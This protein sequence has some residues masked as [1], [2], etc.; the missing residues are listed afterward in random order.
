MRKSS[1]REMKGEARRDP[2]AKESSGR[3]HTSQVDQS[4]NI[5]VRPERFQFIISLGTPKLKPV[6]LIVGFVQKVPSSL[7]AATMGEPMSAP[8]FDENIPSP[9]EDG[10][11]SPTPSHSE[12]MPTSEAPSSSPTLSEK[13]PI[14]LPIED[15][16]DDETLSPSEAP[17]MMPSMEQT[18]PP[19]TATQPTNR[20]STATQPTNTP[21]EPPSAAGDTQVVT[22][23]ATAEGL[24]E[25][26]PGEVTEP[27][28]SDILKL[29][30][31]TSAFY[32][33]VFSQ[34]YRDSEDTVFLILYANATDVKYDPNATIPIQVEWEF[35]VYFDATSEVIP[36][37]EEILQL[38]V[39]NEDELQDYVEIYLRSVDSI[40]NS[41]I[42]VTFVPVDVEAITGRMPE[43]TTSAS[44]TEG[45]LEVKS[46]FPVTNVEA[47]LM[48]GFDMSDDGEEPD[49]ADFSR[50]ESALNVFYNALLAQVYLFNDDTKVASVVT[51]ITDHDF[52][53]QDEIQLMA[54]VA[55][56]VFF[57]ELSTFI[58]SSE[59]VLALLQANSGQL[60]LFITEGFAWGDS[61]V[62]NHVSN[63]TLKPL[64]PIQRQ[65]GKGAGSI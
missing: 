23:N 20:P 38:I 11:I 26:A 46:S 39:S 40:W 16:P 32:I 7:Y 58:P 56:N 63:V 33:G 9:S 6:L 17:S 1:R 2:K 30:I 65:R 44:P 22:S 48:F 12:S 43:P 31:G 34:Y 64:T 5:Q 25:F 54:D 61:H 36:S 55:Y 27:T 50:L 42:R 24:Y 51:S 13:M 62:W 59:T 18:N 37:T 47:T 15:S 3:N 8:S 52:N 45:E 14:N 53:Q 49:Q 57:S 35:Q 60:E 21:T 28:S 10:P 41:T 19:S 29:E 4:C